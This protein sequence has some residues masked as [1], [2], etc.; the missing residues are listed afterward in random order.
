MR[1]FM[2]LVLCCCMLLGVVDIPAYAAEEGTANEVALETGKTYVVPVDVY[3]SSGELVST[4]NMMTKTITDFID[5]VALVKRND[6]GTYHVTL[7]IENYD[8]MD[9]LQISKPG[10]VD[11]SITPTKGAMGTFNVPE[12]FIYSDKV[13]GV[14][15]ATTYMKGKTVPRMTYTYILFFISANVGSLK[16]T[17]GQMLRGLFVAYDKDVATIYISAGGYGGKDHRVPV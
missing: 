12:T 2:A 16:V 17:F 15:H 11:D 14:E 3:D 9:F 10:A 13:D 8:K 4:S 7:Q 6:D 5:N 1:K